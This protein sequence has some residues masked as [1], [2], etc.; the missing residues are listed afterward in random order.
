MKENLKQWCNKPI[1]ILMASV[2]AASLG[3]LLGVFAYY[4]QW[5]G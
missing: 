2:V 4:G 3:G 1:V 5:L